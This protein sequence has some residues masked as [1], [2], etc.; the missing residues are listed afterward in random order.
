M[1]TSWGFVPL[2][3]AFACNDK[4]TEEDQGQDTQAQNPSDPH[5]SDDT[6]DTDDIDVR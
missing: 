5:N 3:L 4:G 2:L 6:A 1:K